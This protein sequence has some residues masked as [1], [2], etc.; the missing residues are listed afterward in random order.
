[1]TEVHT[2]IP[3]SSHKK[4]S[5]CS[6]GTAR[7]WSNWLVLTA[8]AALSLG[9]LPGCSQDAGPATH[10]VKGK[11][12]MP[13]GQPWT[14]GTI[15][16]RSVSAPGTLAT[17]EIQKDG[18]FTL[19][20]HYQERGQPQTRTGAMAGEYTVEVTASGG[21]R[22]RD[23]VSSSPPVVVSKRYQVQPGENDFVVEV[24]MPAGK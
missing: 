15:S 16:F 2:T 17:G 23:G 9:N 19:V 21:T 1:M 6:N 11:V 24:R 8:L 22:D 20:A 10:P 14:G 7:M 12:V 5:N 3:E 13:G 18:T 4:T